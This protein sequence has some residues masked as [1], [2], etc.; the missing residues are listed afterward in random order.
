MC[1][2]PRRRSAAITNGRS[3]PASMGE[4]TRCADTRYSAAVLRVVGRSV[5]EYARLMQAKPRSV[6]DLEAEVTQLNDPRRS[7]VPTCREAAGDLRNT[8]GLVTY[9]IRILKRK[10][11]P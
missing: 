6:C 10:D 5:C 1:R 7:R 4:V 11:A 9:A 3:V 2:G 8:A